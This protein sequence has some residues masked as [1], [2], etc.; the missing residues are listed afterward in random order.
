MALILVES[1]AELRGVG[2]LLVESLA[3]LRGVGGLIEW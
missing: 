2:G 1:L 3:E